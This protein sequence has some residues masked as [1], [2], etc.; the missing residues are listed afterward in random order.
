MKRNKAKKRKKIRGKN[1]VEEQTVKRIRKPGQGKGEEKQK[2]RKE[3]M[4]SR[5]AG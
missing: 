1:R 3:K 2:K 5:V 4:E